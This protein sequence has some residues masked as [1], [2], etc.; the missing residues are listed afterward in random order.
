M[1]EVE[2]LIKFH[3]PQGDRRAELA[4]AAVVLT[5][6][7]AIAIAFLVPSSQDSFSELQGRAL[8]KYSWIGSKFTGHVRKPLPTDDTLSLTVPPFVNVSAGPITILKVQPVTAQNTLKIRTVRI[9]RYGIDGPTVPGVGPLKT[10]IGTGEPLEPFTCP[11]QS[12]MRRGQGTYPYC[13][14]FLG[15]ALG[16]GKPGT[17]RLRGFEITYRSVRKGVEY[18]QFLPNPIFGRYV[19]P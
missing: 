4:A 9:Y 5:I 14:Y 17:Y 7:T 2:P 10:V 3:K 13:P 15:V 19:R 1:S 18:V 11:P 6:A 12:L 16:G 8:L